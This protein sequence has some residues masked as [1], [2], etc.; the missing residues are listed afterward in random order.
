MSEGFEA[1]T[2]HR[3]PPFFL[4]FL[5]FISTILVTNIPQVSVVLF[6]YIVATVKL[7][8]VSPNNY[9][10]GTGYQCYPF[11]WSSLS[12]GMGPYDGWNNWRM[13]LVEQELLTLPVHLSSPLVF[14]GVHVTRS[15]VLYV[16]FVDR[17]L[18]FCNF[19]F[20]H[21]VVCYSSIYGF[22]LPLWYLQTLLKILCLDAIMYLSSQ[23]FVYFPPTIIYISGSVCHCLLDVV[24]KS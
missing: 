15:L 12:H 24:S 10:I 11:S 16:C 23:V 9:S 17:C 8:H 3:T 21:C 1:K 14:S 4:S 13:P 6:L 20:G 2:T 18:S 7:S 19:S 22:W 5:N